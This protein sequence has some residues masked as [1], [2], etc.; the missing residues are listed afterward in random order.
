MPGTI[1]FLTPLG[2]IAAAAVLLPLAGL[3]G[4][5]RRER[6][7]RLLLG[8]PAPQRVRRLPRLTGVVA[9]MALLGLSATQ[10]VLRSTMTARVRTDA[11]AIFVLDVSRSMLAARTAGS[12]TRLTR[13]KRDAIAL[14]NAI[15]QVPSGVATLTDRVLPDLLPNSNP[16]VFNQTIRKAVG[17]EQ[18]PPVSSG[19]VATSLAPLGDLGTQNFFAPTARRRLVVVLTDGESNPFDP[20]AVA[21]GL[22]AGPGIHLIL[23]HV[24]SADEAIFDPGGSRELGYH[25]DPKSGQTLAFLASA[26]NGSVFGEHAI[27]GAIRAEQAAVGT[28]PTIVEGTTG[29]TRTLGPYVALAALVPLVLTVQRGIRRGLV[30][31]PGLVLQ[32][33]RQSTSQK[34]TS[35]IRSRRPSPNQAEPPAL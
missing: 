27:A 26:A 15:P 8:L 1:V 20:R 11:Q 6:Y 25:V 10:P 2:G 3:A 4:T 31:A 24:W 12:Q 16:G 32:I 21:R 18:P 14:R 29:R 5:A 17:I 35:F 7:A 28:G 9:V 30:F 19:V 13:A 23:I 34:R 22:A 33:G